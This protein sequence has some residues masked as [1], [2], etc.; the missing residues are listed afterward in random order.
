[1]AHEPGTENHTNI[2]SALDAA[3]APTGWLGRTKGMILS[4]G[5]ETWARGAS[6]AL[7]DLLAQL[8]YV[9]VFDPQ[10]NRQDALLPSVIDALS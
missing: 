9:E 2:P 5:W 8:W 4:G 10:W 1:M 3:G 6:Q 7:S